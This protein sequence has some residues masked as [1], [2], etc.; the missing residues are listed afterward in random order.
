MQASGESEQ[1]RRIGAHA[2]RIFEVLQ[3]A[4]DIPVDALFR[5]GAGHSFTGQEINSYRHEVMDQ[6]DRNANPG[7]VVG[8]HGIDL[9]AFAAQA[10]GE[11]QFV[12]ADVD[13]EQD[14]LQLHVVRPV[15]DAHVAKGIAKAFLVVVGLLPG[16]QGL[17]LRAPLRHL[18]F[19]RGRAAHVKL[20]AELY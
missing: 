12:Y 20:N 18:P 14:R 13:T 2:R 8:D 10:V 9:S 19:E 11:Q 16:G 15:D 5:L 1:L 4:L 3:F 6:R 7:S 17:M